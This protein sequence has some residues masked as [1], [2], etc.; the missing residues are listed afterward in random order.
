[1]PSASAPTAYLFDSSALVKRYVAEV[2]S[3]WVGA[4]CKP[5]AGN[6]IASAHIGMVEVAAALAAKVRGKFVTVSEYTNALNDLIF[7]ARN[8]YELVQ[9]EQSLIDLAIDLTRRHKLRGYDAVHLAAGL[10]LNAAL[11]ARSLPSLVFVSADN[12][13]LS[14]AKVE[15]LPTDN[16]NAHLVP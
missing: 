8:Q 14:A 3:A 12:D 16:P 7:D 13:L 15:G 9:V 4:L 10:S 5:E 2:G 6:I 1:M 11:L